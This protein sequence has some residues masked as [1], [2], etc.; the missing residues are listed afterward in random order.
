[1]LRCAIVPLAVVAVVGLSPAEAASGRSSDRAIVIDGRPAACIAPRA[2]CSEREAQAAKELQDYVA[3]AT[4]ATLPIVADPDDD[5]RHVIRI[6]VREPGKGE[7]AEA[8]SLE[9]RDKET[10]IVGNSPLGALYGAYELLER[11]VGVRWYVP[12]PLGEVVPKCRTLVLPPLD[13]QEAPSFQMRW[14]GKTSSSDTGPSDEWIVRNK[15][16]ACDDGFVMVPDTPFHGQSFLL[17]VD[18]YFA[19]HPEYFALVD[20]KRKRFSNSVIKLC[21]AAPD[22][23]REIAGNVGAALDANPNV[24]LISFAPSDCGGWCECD[25]CEAMDEKGVPHGQSKSRRNLL[26]YNALAAEVRK[27]HP[28]AGIL[29]GA[30]SDYIVPPRDASLHVDPMLST[31]MAHYGF[32]HSHPVSD[33]TCPPNEAFLQRVRAWRK[34]GCG[35]YFY[36]YYW[37]VAWRELPWPIVHTIKVDIPWFKKQGYKGMYTQFTGQNVWTLYP[38]YYVAARLLWDA[39]A[40]VDA[41]VS[42]MYEDLYGAAASHMKAYYALMEKRMAECGAHIHGYRPYTT[43]PML[44]THEVVAELRRHYDGAVVANGDETVA[45]RLAKIGASLDYLE[46]TRRLWDAWRQAWSDD[47]D[48][49][50]PMGA[51]TKALEIIEGLIADLTVDQAKWEGVVLRE[52]PDLKNDRT[53]LLRRIAEIRALDKVVAYATGDGR[54]AHWPLAAGSGNSARDAGL[55]GLSGTIVGATWVKGGF[56]TALAFS[57]PASTVRCGPGRALGLRDALTLSVWMRPDRLPDGESVLLGEA[58]ASYAI[59]YYR[60]RAHFYINSG[61]TRNN[62]RFAVPL[63]RWSHVAGTFDG[64]TSRLYLNGK[65]VSADAHEGMG[66]IDTRFDVGLCPPTGHGYYG[67]LDDARIY[68]RAVS[69]DEVLTLYRSGAADVIP[70]WSETLQPPGELPSTKGWVLQFSDDFER[71]ELGADWKGL[72]GDWSIEDGRLK[73]LGHGQIMCTKA[74]PGAQ[75]LE[76]DAVSGGQPCDLTAVI[77]AGPLG[78]QY[79]YFVGFGTEDNTYSKLLVQG[80]EVARWEAVIAPGKVHHQVVQREGKTITHVVDG[81]VAMTY[82]DDDPLKGRGHDRIGFYVFGK[83][84]TIDNVRVYTRDR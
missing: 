32:C 50:K 16:N 20:G 68:N 46:R 65:P 37:K 67:L 17:P 33:A 5:Q 72:H 18:K 66:T 31:I 57:G 34:R 78:Y 41:I 7:A 84:Q 62:T 28:N 26:F 38:N 12:G 63:G 21:Y 22:V 15:Q 29:A 73:V 82:N 27:S 48:P 58:A 14:I 54:V 40:D 76:F 81:Q 60:G 43:G 75:R 45:L 77:C 83:S 52:A 49:G 6:L 13:L 64:K 23:V 59:T 69:A 74:F 4:G 10:R 19:K 25:A 80:V 8:F 55:N 44:F 61:G 79:G 3:K 35:I 9:V 39:D 2:G 53:K 56:G 42:K 30:Y 36:E 1:M 70:A 11:G 47:T 24:D 51:A 71:A